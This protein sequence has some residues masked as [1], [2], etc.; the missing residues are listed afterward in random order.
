MFQFSLWYV[1]ATT[2]DTNIIIEMIIHEKHI[3]SLKIFHLLQRTGIF[4]S[5]N[6]KIKIDFT[7]CYARTFFS[8][9]K[10]CKNKKIPSDTI[11]RGRLM[12]DRSPGRSPSDRFAPLPLYSSLFSPFSFPSSLSITGHHTNFFKNKS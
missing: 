11:K 12:G 3:L 1:L 4:A 5:N 7:R 2:I 10:K 6:N 9:N 8:S